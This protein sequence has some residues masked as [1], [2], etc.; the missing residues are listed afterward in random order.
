MILELKANNSKENLTIAENQTRDYA[1]KVEEYSEEELQKEREKYTKMMNEH[2][3]KSFYYMVATV[4]ISVI[5]FEEKQRVS[6]M[7][8]ITRV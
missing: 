2:S 1:F 4:R 6:P 5:D 7:M 8:I 3:E